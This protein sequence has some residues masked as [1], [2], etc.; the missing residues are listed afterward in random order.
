MRK[1]KKILFVLNYLAG[2]GV[3]RMLV[4]ILQSTYKN[5]DVEVLSI[6]AVD[7]FYV[8]E[9]LQFSS[10]NYLDKHRDN[11]N[12]NIFK[13]LYSRFFDKESFQRILFKRFLHHKHYDYV[14]AFS[15]GYAFS[16]V[17]N[18]NVGNAKKIAW[19]HTDYLNDPEWIKNNIARLQRNF[20][21]YDDVIFVGK[22]LEQKFNNILDLKSTSI[23]NNGVDIEK[24]QNMAEEFKP[25]E[26][27]G[28]LEFVSVGRLG[29]EKG[30]DKIIN[31]LSELPSEE[32]HKC[33]LTIVG[34]GGM[35]SELKKSVR[36]YGLESVV[37]F[38]GETKN[39]YPYIKNANALILAS[40]YEGF[41]LVLVEAMALGVPVIATNTTGASD[42]IENGRYGIQ[43]PNDIEQLASTIRDIISKPAILDKYQ[44]HCMCRANDFT[45]GK[46]NDAVINYF[47]NE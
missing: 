7:S 4:N 30:H 27:N 20:S 25:S 16:L 19:V 31:A 41:G 28:K 39:P 38:T 1:K 47:S 18:T 22:S 33:H 17:A 36:R 42:I 26:Q 35:E 43:I 3:E 23:I 29:H 15:E 44:Q 11:I 24:I 32:L 2:G 13:A 34:G 10:I 6:Y 5:F 14:V 8:Q 40:K 21:K 45:I 46:F 9:A 12:S 37:S